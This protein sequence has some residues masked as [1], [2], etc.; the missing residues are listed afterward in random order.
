MCST[1]VNLNDEDELGTGGIFWGTPC[2]MN[3]LSI[4]PRVLEWSIK[5]HCFQQRRDRENRAIHVLSATLGYNP[6]CASAKEKS[7]PGMQ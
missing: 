1:Y 6:N 2:G 7:R 3:G 5:R 4:L